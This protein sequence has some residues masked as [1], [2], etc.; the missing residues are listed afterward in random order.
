MI[1][2]SYKIVIEGLAI[3][4]LALLIVKDQCQ[5]GISK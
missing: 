3:S 1:A 2:K 4:D 5:I